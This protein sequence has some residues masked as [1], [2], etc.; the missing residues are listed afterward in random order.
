MKTQL[1][2][3]EKRKAALEKEC[4]MMEAK[5]KEAQKI[6]NSKKYSKDKNYRKYDA[7]MTRRKNLS[8]KVEKDEEEMKYYE[9]DVYDRIQREDYYEDLKSNFDV[10]GDF[11]DKVIYRSLY[12]YKN[13]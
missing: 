5:K 11:A 13:R 6:Q 1:Q 9:Q 2:I 4:K 8:K 7:E 12:L 3:M 10:I